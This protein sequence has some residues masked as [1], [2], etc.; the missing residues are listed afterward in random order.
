MDI[1]A[2]VCG[3]RLA[4]SFARETPLKGGFSFSRAVPDKVGTLIMTYSMTLQY[5]LAS[6][7]IGGRKAAN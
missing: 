1:C 6:L 4:H 5:D 3:D 7:D 2:H